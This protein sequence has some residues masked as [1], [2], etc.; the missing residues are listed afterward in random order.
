MVRR[1]LLRTIHRLVVSRSTW[2]TKRAV[3]SR[4]NAFRAKVLVA[5]VGAALLAAILP[6]T[7]FEVVW[8][9]GNY[10]AV[11]ASDAPI[12]Y[13]RL[14]ETSGTSAADSSSAHANPLTYQGG[15]TL[16]I[17]PG[18]ING[19]ADPAVAL[20]GSNGTVT[21]TNAT[22][23][24]TTNWTLEAWLNP[25][26]LPQ[27]GVVAY[28]GQ[29]ELAF[30]RLAS[31]RDPRQRDDVRLRVQLQRAQHLVPRRD[32]QGYNQSHALRQRGCTSHH[33]HPDTGR[34]G[35]TILT[36]F[37][38]HVD[39]RADEPICRQHR[40]GRQLQRVALAGTDLGALHGR[41][42]SAERVR[43]LDDGQPEQSSFRPV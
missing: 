31:D 4:T 28:D 43:Q 15:V 36:G 14:D 26:T 20:N 9:A 34:P 35:C 23:T 22:T 27:A 7:Q 33:E 2:S 17:Q 13:W 32:D 41:C 12:G 8:A 39:I 11:A 37:G 3:V 6:E 38:I 25:S 40:R 5:L 30:L 1:A 10:P 21:A 42:F 18:A 24:G 16:V 19:D 29:W